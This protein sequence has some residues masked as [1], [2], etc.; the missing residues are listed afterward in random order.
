M[1]ASCFVACNDTP[2]EDKETSDDVANTESTPVAD[3]GS[4]KVID[5]GALIYDVTEGIAKVEGSIFIGVCSAERAM[6]C[7]L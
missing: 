2:D 6:Q 7:S 1:L 4:L 3:D 5:W